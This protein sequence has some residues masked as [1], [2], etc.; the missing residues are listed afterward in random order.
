VSEAVTTVQAVPDSHQ[1][2]IARAPAQPA[3]RHAPRALF[4]AAALGPLLVLL[5]LALTF[6]RA[7]SFGLAD[8]AELIFRPLVG[9]LLVNTLAITFAVTLAC[10]LLGTA[11]AWLVERTTLPARPSSMRRSAVRSRWSLA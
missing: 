4:A 7:L 11:V 3:R 2:D 9:E 6:W 8:A 10:A 5:P 1:E